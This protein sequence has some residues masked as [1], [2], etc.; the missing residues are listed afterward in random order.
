MSEQQ[1]DY[2]TPEGQ[3]SFNSLP[4]EEQDKIVADAQAE[5]EYVLSEIRP[6]LKE[7]EAMRSVAERLGDQET[8]DAIDQE[9][10]EF[11]DKKFEELPKEFQEKCRSIIS[12]LGELIA[13]NK[14]DF[15][16]LQPVEVPVLNP[17][18]EEYFAHKMGTSIYHHRGV[19]NSRISGVNPRFN[20]YRSIGLGVF[21]K[22][23]A[24]RMDASEMYID[25]AYINNPNLGIEGRAFVYYDMFDEQYFDD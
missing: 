16:N 21:S 9:I 25:Y 18:E 23:N 10:K 2:S 1:P 14:P 15:N 5:A 19:G 6:E 22:E 11:K 17:A 4:E 7:K 12:A 3:E 24:P 8:V 20:T 13:Q